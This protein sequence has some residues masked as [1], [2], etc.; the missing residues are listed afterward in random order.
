MFFVLFIQKNQLQDILHILY[1]HLFRTKTYVSTHKTYLL[2][3]HI[4]STKPHINFS[5]FIYLY[6][7]NLG[8]A[9][10]NRKI[11]I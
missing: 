2:H 8:N 4:N 5:F 7:S 11:C 10:I 3:I 9:N 1:T 6:I